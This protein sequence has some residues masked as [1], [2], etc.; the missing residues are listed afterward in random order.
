MTS[1]TQ[2]RIAGRYRLLEEIGRGGMG[3]VW[4]AHDELLDRTVAVKEVL[5]HA[6]SEQD[7]AAFNLRTVREARAAGRLDHPSV[8]VVHDVIE[9][10]GRPWI[11]MQLVRSRS[12]GQVL[13]E[14]GA[15]SPRRVAE[16]G[17]QVLDALRAAHAAGVLH[18]DVKPENVL[19]TE[20]GRVVL[21]DFG[22]ATM[23][24][25]TALTTTGSLSG[26]PAFLPPERLQGLPAIPESDLWSLGATLYAAVEGRPP[27]DRGAPVPTMAAVLNDEPDPPRRAGPLVPVLEGLLRKDPA[28]RAPA[29]WA[30]EVLGRVAA[31]DPAARG[32][33]E[34]SWRSTAATS[35]AAIPWAAPGPQGSPGPY[36]PQGSQAPY[37]PQGSHGPYGPQGSHAPYGPHGPGTGSPGAR[38]RVR[39][40]VLVLVGVPLLVAL[41][42]AGWY[43]YGVLTDGRVTVTVSEDDR[44]TA[45]ASIPSPTAGDPSPTAS[46]TPKPT[47]PPVTP[48]PSPAATGLPDGWRTHADPLGFRI[49]LPKGWRPVDREATR[50]WF[51]PKGSQT[52]LLVD[53]TRWGE[54]DPL[55][56]L[57]T[58]ERQALGQE[59]LPGYRLLSLRALTQKGREAAEWEFTWRMDAGVAHVRDL[60]FYDADGR[61]VAVYLHTAEKRWAAESAYF[62][63]FAASFRPS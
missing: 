57:R 18:R 49:A 61:Q 53:L 9:E 20:A 63:T 37:G 62:D 38:R 26:T 59:R 56:A 13:R 4:R 47:D 2:R 42:A 12:L 28:L 25:E 44:G 51:R 52:Y 34:G 41:G 19:I 17:A 40:G 43:G 6:T 55:T 54:R 60:A 8:I 1:E 16:I 31:G 11:V 7:R 35:E 50:V 5:H 14:E 27:F 32:P 36:G 3:V 46:A 15:L 24:Q 30:A 58:V 33:A 39:P 21:T 10:D 48:A 29:A 22:I 23:P 45:S